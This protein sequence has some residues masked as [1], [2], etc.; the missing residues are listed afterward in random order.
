MQWVGHV[1]RRGTR[2]GAY[3]VLMGKPEGRRKLGRIRRRWED[4]KMDL[5]KQDG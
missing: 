2:R 5:Q 4:F 1:A 3:R